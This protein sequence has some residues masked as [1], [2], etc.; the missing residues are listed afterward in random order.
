MDSKGLDR[1]PNG[2]T[3]I[4]HLTKMVN[5]PNIKP[6]S[7][8]QMEVTLTSGKTHYGV[9]LHALFDDGFAVMD[10]ETIIYVPLTGLA[11]LAFPHPGV[12]Q[13]VPT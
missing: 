12:S 13:A 8:L 3:L 10:G 2:K 7:P 4:D 11:A 1:M 9:E 5:H 6:G